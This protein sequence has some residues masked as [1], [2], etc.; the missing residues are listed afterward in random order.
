MYDSVCDIDLNAT[1]PLVY[2]LKLTDR[3]TNMNGTI[4]THY[5]LRITN[6]NR[7]E[8]LCQFRFCIFPTNM[9]I[10]Y[11]YNLNVIN[12]NR[13][14]QLQSPIWLNSGSRR[15]LIADMT[16]ANDELLSPTFVTVNMTLCN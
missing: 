11:L 10:T 4:F 13:F 5:R 16:V 6:K 9:K 14:D 15:S 2:Q 12:R 3:L 1:D 8:P 7:S